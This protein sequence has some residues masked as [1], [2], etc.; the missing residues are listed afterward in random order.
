MVVVVVVVVRAR[1][2]VDRR[3]LSAGEE[4]LLRRAPSWQWLSQSAPHHGKIQHHILPPPSAPDAPAI[5]SAPPYPPPARPPASQPALTPTPP[6]NNSPPSTMALASR[7]CARLARSAAPSLKL[8]PV[9]LSPYRRWNSSL[10]ADPKISG[11][12]DQISRLT[13]LETADLVLLLKVRCD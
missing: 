13:L 12:V 1:M 4:E 3:E 11:I 5:N 9:V 2:G 10:A 7:C 8:L 6:N